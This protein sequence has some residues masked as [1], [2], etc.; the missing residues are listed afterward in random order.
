MKNSLKTAILA[1]LI[2]LGFSLSF[3]GAFNAKNIDNLAY[4]VALGLDVG[5]TNNLKLSL[6]IAIPSDSSSMSGSEQS[7]DSIVNSVECSSIESGITLFNSYIS[8][9]IDLSHC[10]VIVFSEKLAKLGIS[11]Y[12]Y[13]L[14]N[15]IQ[16]QSEANIMVCKEDCSTFLKNS[17]PLLEKMSAKYYEIALNSSEYTGY[18][19]NITL[20]TFF[21][22]Y[23]DTFQEASA[24]L[25]SVN[26]QNTQDLEATQGSTNGN[27]DGNYTAGETPIESKSNIEN[28]GL[29]VF[30]DDK[31]VGE[32]TGMETLCQLLLQNKMKSATITIPSPFEDDKIIDLSITLNKRT[33]NTVKIV[34]GS[35]YITSKIVLA[36]RILSMDKNSDNLDK[37]SIQKIEEYAN[38][39]LESNL[40]SFLYKTAKDFKADSVGFGK[41]AVHH[42]LTWDSWTNYDWLANYE[43]SFFDVEVDTTVKSGYF[44]MDS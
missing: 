29:A 14:M 39:Y 16:V 17:K 33:K 18:T 26:T 31:M 19:A 36:A 40:L 25:A 41:Y 20:G 43:N 44:L 2:L 21:S 22:D 1:F 6:Q 10:K 37:E 23:T 27:L 12:L 7:S 11:E 15:N 9:Q 4:V 24:I 38:Q 3:F 13:T 30:R 35:P 28:M 34:N 5:E 8:K 42:F 32:L